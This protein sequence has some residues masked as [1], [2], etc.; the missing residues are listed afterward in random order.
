MAIGAASRSKLNLASVVA[1]PPK[2][3]NNYCLQYEV[4]RLCKENKDLKQR[5]VAIE[6]C[7]AAL[8]K[9]KDEKIE[10]ML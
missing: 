9:C 5:L 8:E 4:E 2:L 6:A 1:T 10:A 7:L 3:D